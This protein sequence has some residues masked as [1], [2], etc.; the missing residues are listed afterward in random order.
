M[1]KSL[2]S[3]PATISIFHSPKVPL[4]TNLYHLL[5]KKLDQ[6]DASKK[7]DQFIIDVMENK[8]PTFDQYKL[9]IMMNSSK[10][11]SCYPLLSDRVD[12]SLKTV[13]KGTPN[14][15][16]MG[17]YTLIYE[18]FNELEAHPDKTINPLDI[19]KP[20][21]IVDWDQQKVAINEEDLHELL[22]IYKVD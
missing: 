7:S 11:K 4:S 21:L 19:F 1:F 6:V 16:N 12:L 15:F 3:S 14:L 17:E 10:V 20:P 22:E 2:Q 13:I 9:L 18:T 8:M 5:Q